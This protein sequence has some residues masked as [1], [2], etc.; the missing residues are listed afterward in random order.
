MGLLSV[1]RKESRTGTTESLSVR[2]PALADMF[3]FS[4]SASGQNVTSDT[5]MRVSAVYACVTVL[6][7]TLAMLPKYIKRL[8]PDGGKDI[9][10]AHRLYKQIHNR[11]NRW[12]SSFEYFEMME[13]HRLLR[14]NAYARIVATPGRGINELIPMHPDR[15]WPFIITPDGAVYFMADNSP[16]PPQRSK[17]YYQYFPINGNTEILLQE[18][19]SHIRDFS[20]NGIVGMSKIGRAAKE[21]IGLA[22]AQE[23]TGAKLFSNGAQISKVFRHPQ[24]MSDVVYNRMKDQMAKFSGSPNAGKTM[25]LEEG[26]D[27]TSLS[28]T[29]ADA[30][31]LEN[32]KFQIEDIARIFNVPLVL[33]GHGDK[34]PTYA[35][36]EQFFMSFKVHTMQ[37]NVTRW[38]EALQRDLLYPSEMNEI[39]IDFDMDSMMRGD[40][41]ARSTYLGKRF[42]MASITPNQIRV[43]EGENPVDDVGSDKLYIQGAT[44][45]LEMAGK[46]TKGQPQ[47]SRE[48]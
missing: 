8:R 6:S 41:V 21:A 27:I 24:K 35:S 29:M 10:Q 17:L 38:E 25:I 47:P 1:A 23:E 19:V 46:M 33:I 45:P 12:Q 11:P 13:G 44:I 40:A 30:Q 7:Q 15:V 26:M 14:G 48:V 20:T 18:E 42:N 39:I 4:T 37:P 43:Y 3:N 2:D 36:A 28:M 32:R 16:M 22:M 9:L 34:A 5:A 31:Y